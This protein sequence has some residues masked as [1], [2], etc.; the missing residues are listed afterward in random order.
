MGKKEEQFEAADKIVDDYLE[1]KVFAVYD[2]NDVAIQV[3]RYD[4]VIKLVRTYFCVQ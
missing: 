2:D 4:D 3:V 1:D